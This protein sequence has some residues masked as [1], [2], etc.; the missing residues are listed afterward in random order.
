MSTHDPRPHFGL[1]DAERVDQHSGRGPV[2]A[3]SHDAVDAVEGVDH[4]PVDFLD[5]L[6]DELGDAVAAAGSAP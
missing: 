4:L 6:D 1:G 3:H 5:A 2:E